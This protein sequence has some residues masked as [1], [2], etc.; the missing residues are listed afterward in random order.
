MNITDIRIR[1]TFDNNDALLALVSITLDDELALHDIKIIRNKDKLFV[2]MP[3]RKSKDGTYHDIV[4]PI[5][6]GMR[7]KIH[8]SIMDAYENHLT[9]M[10]LEEENRQDFQDEDAPP[11]FS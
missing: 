9:A 2:A 5:G 7:N 1:K 11:E 8:E 3:N 4:H 6:S 10:K